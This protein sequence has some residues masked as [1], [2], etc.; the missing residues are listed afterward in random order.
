MIIAIDGPAG[1]GKGTIS[2]LISERLGF[3]YIDTGAMYRA[4]ALKVIR[5]GISI[6]DIGAISEL[7][8]DTNI[9]FGEKQEV[10]LDGEDVSKEIRLP[11]V[12]EFVPKVS[13]IVLVREKM[14]EESASGEN[15]SAIIRDN[16]TSILSFLNNT[17]EDKI[18]RA[19]RSANIFGN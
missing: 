13:S 7:F 11:E 3:V 8:S 16:T 18:A 12:S 4:F 2:K 10:L 14:V 5:K 19:I 1:T 17:L 15:T 9:D 6:D